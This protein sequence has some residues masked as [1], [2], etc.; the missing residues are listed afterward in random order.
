MTIERYVVSGLHFDGKKIK[1]SILLLDREDAPTYVIAAG[2]NDLSKVGMIYEAEFSDTQVS[3]DKR[4][5]AKGTYSDKA[6]VLSWIRSSREAVEAYREHKKP[7][8]SNK[9]FIDGLKE[10]FKEERQMY[11]SLL[12]R[13][14]LVAADNLIKELISIIKQPL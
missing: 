4:E 9:E 14:N 13:G 5:Y 7:K 1:M 3:R 12:E 10:K 8:L 2:I 11:Q 6:L